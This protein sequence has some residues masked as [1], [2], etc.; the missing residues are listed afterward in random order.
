MPFVATV[1]D[2]PIIHD[3]E[4]TTFF[5]NPNYIFMLSYQEYPCKRLHKN[6]FFVK[7]IPE[8]TY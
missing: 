2:E 5:W 8:L 7:E 6:I 1:V 4:Y 3:L